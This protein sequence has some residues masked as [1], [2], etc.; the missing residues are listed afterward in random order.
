MVAIYHYCSLAE[1]CEVIKISEPIKSHWAIEKNLNL[2][3]LL[4]N[5]EY[6]EQYRVEMIKWS[7]EM[8][9]IDYG[10]FCRAACQNGDSMFLCLFNL[11]QLRML[12]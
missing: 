12:V 11:K 1:R 6:K 7:D 9:L 10:Y 3:E 2:N 5:S 4:S 8:R